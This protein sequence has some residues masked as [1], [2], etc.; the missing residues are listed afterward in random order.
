MSKGRSMIHRPSINS[1]YATWYDASRLTAPSHQIHTYTTPHHTTLPAPQFPLHRQDHHLYTTHDLLGF[2]AIGLRCLPRPRLMNRDGQDEHSNPNRN[3][4]AVEL[5][6]FAAN[7][8]SKNTQARPSSPS[9][10]EPS[11]PR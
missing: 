9:I 7:G 11:L 10:C 4:M 6:T 2:N 3:A 1:W 8:L 5:Y